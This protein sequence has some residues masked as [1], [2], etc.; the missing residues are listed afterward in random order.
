M[1][2]HSAIARIGTLKRTIR[3]KTQAPPLRCLCRSS[4]KALRRVNDERKR[5]ASHQD[6]RDD[7]SN[8]KHRRGQVG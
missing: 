2:I 6:R 8:V 4:R 3:I 1:R 5:D 7:S